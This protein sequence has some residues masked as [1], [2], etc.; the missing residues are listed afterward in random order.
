MIVFLQRSYNARLEA[1]REQIIH[2][3]MTINDKKVTS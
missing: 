1:V 3:N 2:N